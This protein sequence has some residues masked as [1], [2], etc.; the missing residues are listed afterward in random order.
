MEAQDL[1]GRRFK[2]PRCGK[3]HE[4][5]VRKIAA[6]PG[7]LEDL[8]EIV[9]QNLSPGGRCLVLADEATWEAAGRRA[10]GLLAGSFSVVE[11]VLVPDGEKRVSAREEYLPG[12]AAAA[13]GAGLVLTVGS[14]TVT[15][16]GKC[17]GHRAGIPVA[18]VATAASMNGYTSGVA[19]ILSGGVKLTLPVTPARAVIADDEIL[20]GAPPEM[21][22][23]GFADF[24][25][26]P[27]AGADWLLSSIMTGE[28]YCSLPM[29]ITGAGPA[30]GL[31][32]R[33]SAGSPGAARE[34]A[35]ALNRGGIG[36]LVAGTSAPA[37]GAEH[38]FSHFLDMHCHQSG[39][40]V[41]AL[42]GLQVGVGVVIAS[43]LYAACASLAPREAAAR[44]C[45]AVPPDFDAAYEA[46]SALF[47]GSAGILADEMRAKRA[48]LKA[49]REK[50][51]AAWEKL[52]REVFPLVPGPGE[53]VGALDAA[54]CPTETAGLGLEDPEIALRAISLARFI[55]RRVTVLDLAAETGLLDPALLD[56]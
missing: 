24:T 49:M 33:L 16:L 55:R 27:C 8:C 38:L 9:R 28:D 56:A 42:H 50:I 45:S 13:R 11:K 26:K 52:G 35:D 29:E 36:M 14:G 2:C 23:A 12:I 4:V 32:R 25:A 40:E 41:F 18:C 17:L 44:L 37:S 51:P 48:A 34:L 5:G 47:P 6:G 19:A 22:R 15:D 39:R 7:V 53:T 54:G 43:R 3:N 10:A 31:A 21:T 1:L 30:E 46:L 20:A